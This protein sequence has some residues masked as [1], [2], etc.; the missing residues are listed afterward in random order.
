MAKKSGKGGLGSGYMHFFAQ[1]FNKKPK[2]VRLAEGMRQER[3]VERG[4]VLT[5]IPKITSSQIEEI[6]F[7]AIN[8]PYTYARIIYNREK[9]EYIYEGI[10]PQLTTREKEM[11]NYLKDTL[12]MTLGYDWEEMTDKDRS[13]YLEENLKAIIKSRGMK[14][15]LLTEDK[16]RY[17]ILRDF[18]GYG[19][20]DILIQDEMVEDTS[21]DGVGIPLFIFHKTLESIKCSVIFEDEDELNSFVILLGQRCGR[22]VS[23]SQPILDG[24]STEGHRIQATYSKEVTTRGA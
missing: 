19:P 15:N 11:M 3:E 1:R 10:E 8:A 21:C 12:K 24:T 9:S 4:S 5:E 18:V 6:D 7:Y 22:Q 14:I 16:L 17:Y 20:I 13:E 2:I 23:V